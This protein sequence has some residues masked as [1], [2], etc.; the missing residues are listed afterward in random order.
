ME[1][2]TT[3][4]TLQLYIAMAAISRPNTEAYFKVTKYTAYNHSFPVL[5]LICLPLH[6]F[7]SS[8][9]SI[10]VNAHHAELSS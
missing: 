9:N 8:P 6:Y 3:C 1:C 7:T 4:T 10:F 2:S 5:F